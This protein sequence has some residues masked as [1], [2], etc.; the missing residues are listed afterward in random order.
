[1][2]DKVIRIFNIINAI[3]ANPGISASDL[4]LKCD[5]NIRTIYRDLDILSLIAPVTNEGRGTG[6][7]FMGKFFVYPLN[8]SEQEALVFSL[9]PS[10]LDHDKLPPGFE[11]AYDKVMATHLKE[12]SKQNSIIENIAEYYSDGNSGISQGKPEFP[13]ADY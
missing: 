7:R 4:A 13:A 3:Q 11:T 12:K 5:V 9:L 10:V 1:M 8:F 6:Y 2:I